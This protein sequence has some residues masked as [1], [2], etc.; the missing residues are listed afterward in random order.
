MSYLAADSLVNPYAIR[1]CPPEKNSELNM[2]LNF[3]QIKTKRLFQST[4]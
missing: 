4:N 1:G 2:R 3:T